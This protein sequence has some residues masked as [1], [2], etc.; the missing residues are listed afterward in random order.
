M[1]RSVDSSILIIDPQL[2]IRTGL[3]SIFNENQFQLNLLEAS[4]GL[5]GL[6][7]ISENKPDIVILEINL[8]KLNG[9]GVI[10]KVRKSKLVVKNT[11]FIIFSYHISER[12][13]ASAISLGVEGIIP[14]ECSLDEILKCL[15]SVASDKQ[16]I[17]SLC[18]K[19]FEKEILINPDHTI[20]QEL[21]AKLSKNET[22]VLKMISEQKTTK[23]IADKLFRSP[24]TIENIRYQ[25][26]RKLDLSGHNSLTIFA[27]KHRELFAL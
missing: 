19:Q 11:K 25:M 5:E 24:K 2:V 21:L 8:P 27:I 18:T 4:D 17:S 20:D 10:E 16:Y 6:K 7:K 9:L 15:K 14:K 1:N 26:C 13:Y 23:E 22:R 3:K 12:D